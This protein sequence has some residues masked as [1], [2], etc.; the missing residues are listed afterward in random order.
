MRKNDDEL[1]LSDNFQAPENVR[2]PRVHF[3]TQ[4]M[5]ETPTN[6]VKFDRERRARNWDDVGPPRNSGRDLSSE[7]DYYRPRIIRNYAPAPYRYR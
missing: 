1:N 2:A 4:G 7:M 6:T 5:I 3:V